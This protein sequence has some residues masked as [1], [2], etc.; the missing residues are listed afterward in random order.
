MGKEPQTRRLGRRNDCK[1]K[2]FLLYTVDTTLKPVHRHVGRLPLTRGGL[3][4]VFV[5]VCVYVKTR[6]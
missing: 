6:P 4:V 3:G 5:S 1:K 2:G